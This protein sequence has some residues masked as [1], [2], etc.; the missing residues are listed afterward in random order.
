M[1]LLRKIISLKLITIIALATL[2]VST[3]PIREAQATLLLA[4]CPCSF[5]SALVFAR[6]EVRQIGGSFVIEQCTDGS[7]SIEAF[8]ENDCRIEFEAE[9]DGIGEFECGY[10]FQCGELED[11]GDP[12]IDVGD[13]SFALAFDKVGLSQAEFEACRRQIKFISLLFFGVGCNP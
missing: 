9:D 11:T 5:L 4:T 6:K 2:F 10:E 7:S 12:E 13:D 8:G 3:T 1:N